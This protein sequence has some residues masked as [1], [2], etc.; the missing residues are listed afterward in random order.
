MISAEQCR[1]YAAIC[2]LLEGESVERSPF[3]V[4]MSSKWRALAAQ[5][6]RDTDSNAASAAKLLLYIVK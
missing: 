2:D 5:I 6:D 1:V 4:A 3:Q